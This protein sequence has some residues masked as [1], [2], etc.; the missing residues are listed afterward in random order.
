MPGLVHL[1]FEGAQNETLVP[2]WE[3]GDALSLVWD[4]PLNVRPGWPL[5]GDRAFVDA[6]FRFSTPLGEEYSGEWR[7]ASTFVVTTAAVGAAAGAAPRTLA[8]AGADHAT[9]VEVLGPVRCEA[10]TGAS[11]AGT[12]SVTALGGNFGSDEPPQLSSFIVDDPD[13]S[14]EAFDPGDTLTLGGALGGRAHRE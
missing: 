3:V 6:L 10:G 11:T 4:A 14:A 12:G 5:S 9:A 8:E 7:D 2:T 1:A 13:D